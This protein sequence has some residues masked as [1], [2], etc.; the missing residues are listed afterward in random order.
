MR[1]PIACPPSEGSRREK[2]PLTVPIVGTFL[3]YISNDW[4]FYGV[5]HSVLRIG[6]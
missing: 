3:G 2:I 5:A 1:A 4:N 6:A